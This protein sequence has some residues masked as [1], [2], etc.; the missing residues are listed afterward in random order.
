MPSPL[1]RKRTDRG[2]SSIFFSTANLDPTPS[3]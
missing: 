3:L 2:H 1:G